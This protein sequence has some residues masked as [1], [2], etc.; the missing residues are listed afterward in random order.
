MK[1]K[2]AILSAILLSSFLATSYAGST[3]STEQNNDG[4]F[5]FSITNLYLSPGANNL[6]YAVHTQPVP[7]ATPT[8]KQEQVDPD[9][10]PTF[11]TE[12][13]YLFADK[14]D[15]IKVNWLYLNSHDS[16]SATAAGSATDS[17]AP[18]YYFGPLA[19]TLRGTNAGSNVQ[20]N[21]SHINWVYDHTFVINRHFSIDPFG[22]VGGAYLKQYIAANY[23]GVDS[24]SLAFSINSYNRSRYIG[25]GPRLGVSA[26]GTFGKHFSLLANL[27]GT[28]MAGDMASRTTFSSYGAGTTTPRD[29]SL[30]DLS[31]IDVVPEVDAKL[32]MNYSYDFTAGSQLLVQLGYMFSSYIDGINQVV[33]TALVPGAFS[34][35]S[36][37]IETSAQESSDFDING[38][39]IKLGYIF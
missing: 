21:L 25:A 17:V 31:Q 7:I 35:G 32:A 38:P 27:A 29:S 19:Q 16:A 1:K 15:Q 11:S 37:A 2:S 14:I 18:P 3:E 39:Y 4:Y 30:A 10:H 22:G 26:S 20:F 8:W 34:G 24:S 13:S 5:G 36:I 28:I 9:Y 33:P 23:S 6:V 12:F